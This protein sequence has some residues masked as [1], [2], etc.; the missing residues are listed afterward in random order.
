[1]AGQDHLARLGREFNAVVFG[2]GPDNQVG[3]GGL[4]ADFRDEHTARLLRDLLVLFDHARYEGH[5]PR[6]VEVVCAVLGTCFEG[7]AQIS[8]NTRILGPSLLQFTYMLSVLRVRPNSCDQ[9]KRLL[10]QRAKV[11][12]VQAARFDFYS[13]SK[14]LV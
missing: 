7:L 4:D 3:R 12:S 2:E 1:M 10:G 14:Q 5:L 13:L 11:I 8:I 6:G 9:D